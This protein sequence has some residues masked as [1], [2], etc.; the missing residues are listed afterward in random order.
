[1]KETKGKD[2]TKQY[3]FQEEKNMKCK[4]RYITK[5]HRC[6]FTISNRL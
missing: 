2:K 5:G 3:R 1:M 6:K 4:S